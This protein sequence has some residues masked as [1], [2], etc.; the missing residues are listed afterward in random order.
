[1]GRQA[2]L[3]RLTLGRSP[4][5]A[6]ELDENGNFILGEYAHEFDNSDGYVQQFNIRG[7][8]ENR[9]SHAAARELRRA[10]NDV[11]STVGVV[12]SKKNLES[13]NEPRTDEKQRTE[14]VINENEY[15]F[16]PALT[17][18]V[19]SA[20][21]PLWM[22]GMRRR[23][24][25]FCSYASLPLTAIVRSE[26]RTLGIHGA[27][28]SGIGTHLAATLLQNFSNE[29]AE[30][31]AEALLNKIL[32]I[33]K[34]RKAK[35][36]RRKQVAWVSRA[37]KI[38]MLLLYVPI[39]IHAFLQDLHLL[40]SNSFPSPGSLVPF[41]QYSPLR[42]EPAFESFRSG[43]IGA[44]MRGLARSPLVLAYIFDKLFVNVSNVCFKSI[45]LALRK[46]D[47]PDE[48]SIK[49]AAEEDFDETVIPGLGSV[50][51]TRKHLAIADRVRGTA[52][53]WF[54]TIKQLIMPEKVKMALIDLDHDTLDRLVIR[55]QAIYTN[56]VSSVGALTQGE[57]HQLAS[58]AEAALD[59]AC[60][61]MNIELDE[62]T[63]LYLNNLFIK[64]QIDA[65]A[66]TEQELHQELAQIGG[67]EVEQAQEALHEQVS[68]ATADIMGIEVPIVPDSERHSSPTFRN[69]E[70]NTPP[71]PLSRAN[72]LFS[73][74]N[75]SPMTTPPRSPRMRT[76]LMYEEEDTVTMQ[77]ELVPQRARGQGST[78]DRTASAESQST[79][80]A[81]TDSDTI[82]SNVPD[83]DRGDQA[84]RSPGARD[85]ANEMRQR[86]EAFRRSRGARPGPA[87]V[88]E[89]VSNIVENENSIPR[90][91]SSSINVLPDINSATEFPTLGGASLSPRND[92]TRGP[93]LRDTDDGSATPPPIT[94]ARS[95]PI[96]R[97]TT[98]SPSYFSTSSFSGDG[99]V[100]ITQ[101]ALARRLSRYQHRKSRMGQG[102]GNNP[103]H[104]VS[105]LSAF[106]AD[107]FAAHAASI[108]TSFI[109]LPLSAVYVRS[110]AQNFLLSPSD[111]PGA[112]E[113]ASWLLADVRSSNLS[114]S[115][116][117]A[118]DRADLW[119][120]VSNMACAFGLQ[121]VV[122]WGIWGAGTAVAIGLGRSWSGWGRL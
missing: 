51:D 48:W 16:V 98:T 100:A 33:P 6:P 69:A 44:G 47:N 94:R 96:D 37:L 76:S 10:A 14:E 61:E 36:F 106:P 50:D 17:D 101:P 46:P 42:V 20:V 119:N 63:K 29:V 82:M 7:H 55:R 65:L 88:L 68:Q 117:G 25:V 99:S 2:Y 27:M 56:H 114:F 8:P 45:R 40:P 23:I 115:F 108:L 30:L 12:V 11:L 71:N 18:Q 39:E 43:K 81:S 121:C 52:G 113:T 83:Q 89:S 15:G 102:L 5:E 80:T 22:A 49:A 107:S 75:P 64:L 73:E 112:R 21:L 85:V 92:D 70:T 118:R 34:S 105:V 59:R 67:P 60:S 79:I 74:L 122:S 104:R 91:E 86:R 35:R 103:F 78:S 3:T 9:Q 120:L 72:T 41:S 26:I 87:E 38:A 54:L 32:A 28:F 58:F 110:V 19:L 66:Q 1:M 116:F 53:Y 90:T 24:L 57:T 111:R 84:E 93:S 4:Y 31:A 97:P 95:L 13:L 109:M 62:E 77:L